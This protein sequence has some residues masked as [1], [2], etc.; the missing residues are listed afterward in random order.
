MTLRPSSVSRGDGLDLHVRVGHPVQVTQPAVG[1]AYHDDGVRGAPLGRPASRTA[2][3]AVVP[4]A[5][6][7]RAAGAELAAAVIG[8]SP[9]RI[10]GR[11][12]GTMLS[13]SLRAEARTRGRS[14]S[15][16]RVVRTRSDRRTRTAPHRPQQAEHHHG[17]G[18]QRADRL[19]RDVL[20]HKPGHHLVVSGPRVVQHDLRS[21]ELGGQDAQAQGRRWPSPARGTEW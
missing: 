5:T 3:P 10:S 2:A 12:I 20:A 17:C 7:I 21:L 8:G 18:E 6:R 11:A 4:A 15:S 13:G 16:A 19:H 1:I 9:K 14:G